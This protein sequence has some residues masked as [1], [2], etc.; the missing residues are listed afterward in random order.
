MCRSGAQPV[1]LVPP[2]KL[3][4]ELPE[5]HALGTIRAGK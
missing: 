2:G 1:H 5:L 4:F 3:I